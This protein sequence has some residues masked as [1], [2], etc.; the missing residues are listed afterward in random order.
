M[1]DGTRKPVNRSDPHQVRESL[2][3]NSPL[4][5]VPLTYPS[6]RRSALAPAADLGR[7][8]APASFAIS[9]QDI[10]ALELSVP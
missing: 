9:L 2:K 1:V 6:H 3:R 10:D 7:A 8:T 5:A 4:V